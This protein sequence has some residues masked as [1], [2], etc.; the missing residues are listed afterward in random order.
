MTFKARG[1][2]I[3]LRLCI[4]NRIDIIYSYIGTN[5]GNMK[6]KKKKKIGYSMSQLILVIMNVPK[7]FINPREY[8]EIFF[9]LFYN[10]I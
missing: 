7:D 1:A 2:T 4:E 6:L 9:L 3:L 8:E 10:L 5:I